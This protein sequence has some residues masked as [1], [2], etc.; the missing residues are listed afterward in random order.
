MKNH[1]LITL[2][3]LLIAVSCEGQEAIEDIIVIV[4]PK[5][6]IKKTN[7]ITILFRNLSQQDSISIPSTNGFE[8]NDF[9][10]I[11]E[12][13]RDGQKYLEYYNYIIPKE[14]GTLELPTI[15][16]FTK[17][18]VLSAN[19]MNIEVVDKIP[20]A[21]EKEIILKLVSDKNKY[22]QKDTIGFS[23]YEY[24]KYY[25]VKKVTTKIDSI[26]SPPKVEG[27]DNTL[28]FEVKTNLYKLSG[29][30]K[31]E[32]QLN[33]DFEIVDLDYDI[34]G[35]GRIM[36]ELYGSWY[37]KTLLLSLKVVSKRK[38]KHTIG[39]S[40]FIYFI[41]KSDSDFLETYIPNKDGKGYTVQPTDNKIKVKSNELSFIVE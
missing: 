14:R 2:S 23:L 6:E 33:S 37:I 17:D 36:E 22:Q 24:S 7:S 28:R 29:N 40:E 4:Q 31:L 8:F 41:S 20:M 1:I 32:D 34:F 25:K 11:Q 35:E 19:P 26:V 27:R 3:I 30:E 16:G 12:K 15:Q 10:S 18:K 13:E 9:P 38:G 21:T 39:P 5:M